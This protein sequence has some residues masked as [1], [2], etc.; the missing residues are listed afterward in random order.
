MPDAVVAVAEAA[1]AKINLALHVVGRRADGY[2]LLES[3]S[4]FTTF[5]DRVTVEPASHDGFFVGGAF[6]RDV[7]DDAANLVV[8][9]RDALRGAVR[10]A[11]GR[12]PEPVHIVLEK[13]LPVMSGVGG[14]SSDA[15][16]A[17]RALAL[18]WSLDCDIARLSE[19]GLRLGADV[20]MCLRRVPL[21][22][23]GIGEEIEGVSGFPELPLVLVNPRV[24]VA[25]PHVF[26]AL[27]KRD[28]A[29]VPPLPE[30]RDAASLT[31]WLGA[32]RNDLMAPALRLAP[33]IGGALDALAGAGA[34]FA[35]MSGSG[36][37]C[38]GLF[39]DS[40]AARRAA[41]AISASRPDW[42]VAATVTTG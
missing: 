30:K 22:A 26:T 27:A 25:T 21:I 39:G 13:N 37:T 15:A 29:P 31:E 41:A 24:A 35:R 32:T 8:K 11:G 38:F 33:A 20:P 6:A 10:S 12:S 2:H 1:P 14:G 3:L 28:N 34:G 42:F 16:A 5:G 17:L 40:E 7:P 18:H 4:V 19:I 9:A 36:A 23:R